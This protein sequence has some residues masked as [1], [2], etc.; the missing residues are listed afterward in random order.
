ML[1]ERAHRCEALSGADST[2]ATLLPIPI[3][4]LQDLP[5]QLQ[6]ISR[7]QRAT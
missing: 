2:R 3:L 5:V 7:E 6:Q 4:I 1:A